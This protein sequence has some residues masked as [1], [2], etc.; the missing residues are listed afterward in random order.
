MARHQ[1]RVMDYLF[2]IVATHSILIITRA[3][4]FAGGIWR[5]VNIRHAPSALALSA[6]ATRRIGGCCFRRYHIAQQTRYQ[7][8]SS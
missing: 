8:A 6:A 1:N 4:R 3:Y 7:R 2:C 5:I